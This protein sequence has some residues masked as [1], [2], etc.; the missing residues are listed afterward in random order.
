MDHCATLYLNNIDVKS[1]GMDH[2]AK[3]YLLY[4]IDVKSQGMDQC[5]NYT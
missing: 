4:N 5:V 2:C 1:Q 3:L